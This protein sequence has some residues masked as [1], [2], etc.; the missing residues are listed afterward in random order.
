M[1]NDSEF[2]KIIEKNIIMIYKGF[3]IEGKQHQRHTK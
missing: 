2:Y 3:L 1:T